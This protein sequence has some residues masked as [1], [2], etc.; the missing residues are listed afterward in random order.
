VTIKSSEKFIE[1]FS[2]N[3]IS[4]PITCRIENTEKKI[5]ASVPYGINLNNLVPTITISKNATISPKSE[6]A[7]NFNEPVIYNIT[8]EDGSIQTYTV[9]LESNS[10]EY[11]YGTWV[12]SEI[13]KNNIWVQDVNSNSHSLGF[14]FDKNNNFLFEIKFK[15]TIDNVIGVQG[16]GTFL[17]I[18]NTNNN[19]VLKAVSRLPL[20]TP[21][22]SSYPEASIIEIINIAENELHL[23][24]RSDGEN[25]FDFNE[26]KLKKCPTNSFCF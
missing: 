19:F 5:T 23:K 7:Q 6:I 22:G 3:T 2:F 11:I 16:N 12:S 4:P 15:K 21:I 14:S 25:Y 18:P 9:K 20:G 8:A 1:N 17:L 26:V 13:K 10:I 24:W